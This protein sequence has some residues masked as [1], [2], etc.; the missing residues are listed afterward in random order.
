MNLESH[1]SVNPSRARLHTTLALQ[2]QIDYMTHGE[3]GK[4]YFLDPLIH[5]TLVTVCITKNVG[6][7]FTVSKDSL[8]WKSNPL[9]SNHL[10]ATFRG[11]DGGN[12]DW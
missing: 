9:H 11:F 10:S 8:V 7:R 5:M 3:S 6:F 12:Y 2:Q 4:H 1:Q